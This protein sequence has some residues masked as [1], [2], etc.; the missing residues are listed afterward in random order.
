M[1]LRIRGVLIYECNNCGAF[2][3]VTLINN[4][5]CPGCKGNKLTQIGDGVTCYNEPI[6]NNTNSP[7]EKSVKEVLRVEDICE[8]LDISIN[9]GYELMNSPDFP[10]IELGGIKRVRREAFFYWLHNRETTL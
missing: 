8:F 10:L 3:S 4:I 7:I 5:S 9:K 6:R 2:F 1:N